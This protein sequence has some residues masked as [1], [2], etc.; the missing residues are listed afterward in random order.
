MTKVTSAEDAVADIE[1]GAVVASVGVL[2]WITPDCLLKALADRFNAK[3]SPRDLTFYFPVATGD[4]M[5]IKGMDHVAIKGLMKRIVSG[6]YINPVDPKTGERPRVMSL[7]NQ[8]MV[9]AYSWPIGA[10]MQWL[11]EVARKSPGYMTRV[12]LGTYIDPDWTGGK[13]TPSAQEDLVEKVNFQGEQYLFYP[14]WNID[15]AFIRAT[16]SD[17]LGNLSFE[18][19]AIQSSAL[20]LAI[21][22]KACGGTVIAQ[23]ER[24][25]PR[26]S[27]KAAEVRIPACLVD[28]VVVDEH[29]Q[30]VTDIQHDDRFLQPGEQLDNVPDLPSG[31]IQVFARRAAEE[32]R[33][34]E[35]T[36]FGFGASSTVQLAMNEAGLFE[37]GGIGNYPSTTEHGT[38]GGIV[39]GGWQFSA[40]M[41]PDALIDGI[42]QFD[43][44]GGGLCKLAVLSFAQFDQQGVINVSRFAGS[45]PG[46]GGFIDIAQNAQRLVFTGTFT[47]AG[48]KTEFVDGRLKVLREGKVRKFV[49]QADDVTYRV[50]E[51]IRERF[52]EALIVTERAVFKVFADGLELIEIAPGIDLQKHILDQMGFPP[53]R[54]SSPIKIMDKE[55]F[56]PK[57]RDRN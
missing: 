48:L 50:F 22:V 2:A 17:D 32:V 31:P 4:A 10:S 54:I 36:I 40:N 53:V 1:D 6:S 29:Q 39:M 47:T 26:G 13:I 23:V 27:R 46:A 21:A 35:L 38:H 41:Y 20:A 44:I 7:I 15:V 25:V 18:K 51:G 52:Q 33:R 11:R 16:S 8:D 3:G 24:T 56:L 14:T 57:T 5:E 49:K 45:N 30:M 42:T 28:R 34:G 12:G 9:E 43:L 37:D 19:E 55:F